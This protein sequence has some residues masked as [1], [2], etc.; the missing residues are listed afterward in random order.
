MKYCGSC[1]GELSETAKF[2]HVCGAPCSGA[3]RQPE[4]ACRYC[5]ARLEPDDMFCPEC[6]KPRRTSGEVE[7]T[8]PGGMSVP[9]ADGEV[10]SER[11]R[12]ACLILLAGCV[13]LW[14]AAPFIAVDYFSLGSQPTALQI[15]LEDYVSLGDEVVSMA[16]WA[17]L[18]PIFGITVCFISTIARA[19]TATRVVAIAAELP[20]LYAIF[21][22]SSWTD[23]FEEFFA[24]LGLGFWGMFILLLAVICIV[25][26]KSPC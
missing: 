2:C 13:F 11:S 21:A 25:G 8:I 15:L 17:A 16:F 10:Q 1:G 26:R 5:G 4:N 23:D 20:M 12:T 7:S 22:A 9:K 18:I 3:V 14:L 6:G 24:M 19:Y